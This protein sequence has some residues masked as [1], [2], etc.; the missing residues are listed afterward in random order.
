M[1]G[2]VSCQD[3]WGNSTTGEPGVQLL[4]I[5]ASALAAQADHRQRIGTMLERPQLSRRDL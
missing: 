3:R 2:S 1:A 5:D 4:G